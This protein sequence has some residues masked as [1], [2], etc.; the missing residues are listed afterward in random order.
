[1]SLVRRNA[2]EDLLRGRRSE[3]GFQAL[4][5]EARVVE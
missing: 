2:L 5:L 1:M 3:L 4:M